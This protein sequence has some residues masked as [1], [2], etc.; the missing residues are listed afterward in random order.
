MKRVISIL[1]LAVSLGAAAQTYNHYTTTEG[2]EWQQSKAS[3]SRKAAADP[4]LSITGQEQ[5]H[6]F[7]A[8]GTCFNELDLDALEL[9]KQEEQ[10]EVMRRL[11]DPDGD[12]RFT[13]GR[14]TMNA[15][16]YSRAWYS[17]DTVAGD[18]QLKYFNIEHDKQ[19]VIRLIKKAQKYQPQMTFWVSPWSPPAWMKIN[20]D[21][22]VMS[23]KWNKQQPEKDYLLFGGGK[24]DETEVMLAGQQKDEDAVVELLQ[25]LRK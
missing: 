19:N 25:K 18:F 23:S 2:N 17:C 3:L 22:P 9:L 1:G 7:K 13:R 20:Q 10:E 4:V 16:D 12:L 15:N 5:G 6:V 24:V 14:L 8:W 11:F 21:Y